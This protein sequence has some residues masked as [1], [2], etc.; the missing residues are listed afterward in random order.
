ML[1]KALLSWPSADEGLVHID[2]GPYQ[3]S[4][5][6]QIQG[7]ISSALA[8]STASGTRARE[9]GILYECSLGPGATDGIVT[10]CR[11]PVRAVRPAA[12]MTPGGSGS[13]STQPIPW[14]LLMAL[15]GRNSIAR[16]TAASE[17]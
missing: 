2:A 1:T 12:Q 5:K 15:S 13:S 3:S 8:A 16:S 9:G 4:R 17:P 6:L 14:C 11:R 7:T 10:E